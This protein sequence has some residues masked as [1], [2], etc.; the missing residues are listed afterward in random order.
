MSENEIRLDIFSE[1]FTKK[2]NEKRLQINI[3]FTSTLLESNIL[4]KSE[5]FYR[6][7]DIFM[8]K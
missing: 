6:K 8:Y 4:L 7:N 5:N 1:G 2:T 3:K